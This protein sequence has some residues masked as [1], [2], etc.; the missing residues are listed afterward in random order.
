MIRLSFDFFFFI[1]F[2]AVWLVSIRY[3]AYVVFRLTA[4]V[5]FADSVSLFLV[6]YLILFL[7]QSWRRK[8]SSNFK[9]GR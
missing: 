1:S 3:V 4:N 5:D 8:R 7:I 2:S 9:I 6:L